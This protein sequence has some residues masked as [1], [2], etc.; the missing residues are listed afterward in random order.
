MSDKEENTKI[1]KNKKR[2]LIIILI[3]LASLFIGYGISIKSTPESR[4]KKIISYL[5]KK[6][7][8]KFEIIEMTSSGEH[9]ILHEISCDGATFCPEIKDK[10]VYYYI[11][12]VL[13]LSDNV[14]FEVEYLDKR[15]K[16]KITEITTYYSLAHTNDI[17]SDINNYI[18]SIMG[19]DKTIL[20]SKSISLEFD[21]KFDEICDSNYK[22]KLEKISTYVKEKRA[23]DKDLDIFVY[24]EYSDE[25]SITFGF[26]DPIVI[27]RSDEYFDG[28]EGKDI[29]SGKYMKVYHSLDEYLDR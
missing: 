5:E 7:N 9:I 12:N 8:S 17:L 28:A 18:I 6:Y 22:Q 23:L 21:E 19:N 13:S 14:T 29:S 20:D 10:G 27:K 15:L 25:I 3:I 16:D 1:L 2:N 24:F 26:K 4:E 11:Y